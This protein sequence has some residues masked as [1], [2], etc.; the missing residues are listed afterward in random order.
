[1][2][3]YPDGRIELWADG[4]A[5][6]YAVFDPRETIRQA[7]IVENKRLGHMLGIAARVQALRDDRQTAGPSRTMIG[8]APTSTKA[9]RHTKRERQINRLDMERVIAGSTAPPC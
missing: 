2:V 3:E 6:P 1:V 7:D 5:L 9:A 8:A 4:A